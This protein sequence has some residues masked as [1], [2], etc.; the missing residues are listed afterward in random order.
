[1]QLSHQSINVW[2]KNGYLLYIL[3]NLLNMKTCICPLDRPPLFP[4]HSVWLKMDFDCSQKLGNPA[5]KALLAEAFSLQASS[6]MSAE[7]A[8]L[9][10]EL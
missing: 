5:P 4:C 10:E 3:S 8:C 6:V 1:M 2:K 9:Q 7:G